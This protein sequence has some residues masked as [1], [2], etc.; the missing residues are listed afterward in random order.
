[1]VVDEQLERVREIGGRESGLAVVTTLRANGSMQASIVNAGV[2]MHPRTGESVVGFA[3]RGSRRK[4]VHLRARPLATLVFRSGWD[5]VAVEGEADLAGPSD[6]Q[7]GL[8]QSALLQLLREIYAA[9]VGGTAEDWVGM[10]EQMTDEGHS[11]VL[12]RPSRIYSNPP[13]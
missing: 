9:A 10:D 1:M 5:W 4:L 3:V 2:V 7:L 13:D 8:D 12:V 6:H 11:A